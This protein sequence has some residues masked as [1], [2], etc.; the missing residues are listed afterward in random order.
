MA[1]R[2]S[3]ALAV[4]GALGAIALVVAGCG[5]T[6][7]HVARPRPA[8]QQRS[9]ADVVAGVRSGVVKVVAATCDG[10]STGTGF[11][12]GPNLV[13]TVDHV[14]DG[15][16]S[17][18]LKRNGA[19]L[20]EAKVIG[21]D[22]KRDLALLRT[23]VPIDGHV[24]KLA[25]RAPRLGE[26]VAALGFP[27]GL[28]LTVTRGTAS[29]SGRSVFIDGATRRGL[30]Q[31]DAA[32]NHGNSGGPLLSTRTGDV[33]G[34]VDLKETDASGI[35]FAVSARLAQP[36]LNAWRTN[37]EPAT[38]ANCGGSTDASQPAATPAPSTPTAPSTA[39]PALTSYNG[40]YFS[41]T[42]PSAWNVDAADESK[43]SYFDTT[44]RSDQDTDVMLRADVMPSQGGDPMTS[45]RQVE[46]DLSR[47]PGYREISFA[48]TTFAGYNAVRWEFLVSESGVS[49]HKTDTFFT[50][51]NG[52]QYAV[53][54]QA[55]A[56]SYTTWKPLLDPLAESLVPYD[57]E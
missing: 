36:L 12:I 39:P 45:A 49:L 17:V 3:H 37:P 56:N 43:G 22:G 41:L 9:L 16:V 19:D 34:L 44:I 6:S 14:V 10:T 48:S 55:P 52:N 8:V 15:A 38:A 11:L 21:S 24:F 40:S 51:N 27:L 50:T 23:T 26:D 20:G 1:A 5:N 46:A 57:G 30:I 42:Y 18:K 33:L 13:A 29:G 31:T 7:T 25:P 28:P 35:G 4:L 32:V 47:Q 53:L 54:T 2:R